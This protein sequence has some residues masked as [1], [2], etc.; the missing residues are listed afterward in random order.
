VLEVRQFDQVAR[1]IMEHDPAG[2]GVFFDTPRQIDVMVA[3]VIDRRVEIIGGE[4]HD[5]EAGV[6]DILK[7]GHLSQF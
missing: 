5:R 3:Q 6:F 4:G 7:V 1:R 2:I